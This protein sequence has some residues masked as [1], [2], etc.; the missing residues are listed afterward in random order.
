MAR[1]EIDGWT[2]KNGPFPAV[3]SDIDD[4]AQK[5]RLGAEARTMIA[6]GTWVW[7]SMAWGHRFESNSAAITGSLID[8][9]TV[10]APGQSLDQDWFETTAGLRLPVTE[11]STMTA[12]GPSRRF[13][14]MS[15]S[16]KA[17]W[18]SAICFDFSI[19]KEICL[20]TG[21]WR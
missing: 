19:V 12:S 21:R 7:G 10:T 15:R 6:P 4:T 16:F 17:G 8:L 3:I 9:F 1:V 18:V 11:A 13:Q 2:E 5:L 14:M 20:P